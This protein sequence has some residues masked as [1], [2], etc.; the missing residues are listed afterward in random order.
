MAITELAGVKTIMF[1]RIEN[2]VKKFFSILPS[3]FSFTTTITLV[4]LNRGYKI[5]YVFIHYY[6]R[7]YAKPKFHPIKDTINMF[8]LIIQTILYF[9]PLKIFMPLSL[10]M[11]T[12]GIFIFIWSLL[13]LPKILDITIALLII[14]GIQIMAIGLIA[15]LINKKMR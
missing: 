1:R 11:I 9:N 6:N 12:S 13:F 15:D 7:M 4:M 10:A 8:A 2:I 3:G 5:K 14:T